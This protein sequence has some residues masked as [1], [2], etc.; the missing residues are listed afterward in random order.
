M[1]EIGWSICIPHSCPKEDIFR[2][3]NKTIMDVGEGL[4]LKVIVDENYCNYVQ[5]QPVMGKMQYVVL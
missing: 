5:S 1:T 2:H 3:L 4:D